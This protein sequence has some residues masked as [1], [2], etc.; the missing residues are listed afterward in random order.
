MGSKGEIELV[1]R[2]YRD[3]EAKKVVWTVHQ[4][5]HAGLGNLAVTNV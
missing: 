4:F 1:I 5:I 2:S 3:F